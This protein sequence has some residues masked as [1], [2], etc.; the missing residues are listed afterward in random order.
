MWNPRAGAT[1]WVEALMEW[2]PGRIDRRHHHRIPATGRVVLR[3]PRGEIHGQ[4]MVLGVND[5]EVECDLG[6][7]LLSMAGASVDVELT[8]HDSGLR[9]LPMRGR[10]THVRAQSHSLV[11][12]LTEIPCELANVIEASL[13]HPELGAKEAVVVI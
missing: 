6:F 5:L 8:L 13:A 11:V 4:L 1:V 7:M 12:R 2:R 9:F 3:V 10:V